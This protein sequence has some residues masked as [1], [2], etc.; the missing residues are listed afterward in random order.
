MWKNII[1]Y[2]G[3]KLSIYLK[4]IGELVKDMRDGKISESEFY[5]RYD[6]IDSQY[7]VKAMNLAGKNSFNRAPRH[8]EDDEQEER[9]NATMATFE[10]DNRRF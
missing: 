9:R 4:K 1:K 3:E 5:D 6:K 2:D 10:A 7:G 8:I